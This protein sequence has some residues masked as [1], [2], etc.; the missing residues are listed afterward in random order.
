MNVKPPGLRRAALTTTAA[1]A[2]AVIIWASGLLGT[3][4]RAFLDLQTRWLQHEV[5]SDIIIVEIDA[6]SLNKLGRWPLP[7]S[8]YAKLLQ[9][10][11]QANARRIFMDIDFSTVST[12]AEDN[13]L[14]EVL[15]T[16][17]P[18][19]VLPAFWQP[20][21]NGA[22]SLLLNQPLAAFRAH[23]QL[24][25]VNL[26][27]SPDGL[28]RIIGGLSPLPNTHQP[29]WAVMQPDSH[30][31]RQVL[32]LDYR[33]SPHSFER[34]S[35]YDVLHGVSPSRFTGK[36]VFVGATALEL[37]DII[38]VP[39]HRVLPGILVQAI[40]YESARLPPLR[41][42][43]PA[44]LI[45]VLIPWCVFCVWLL[46]RQGWH[47]SPALTGA[48]IVAAL[49]ATALLYVFGNVL[50]PMSPFA[51]AALSALTGSLL[52][53]LRVE[54]WRSWRARRRSQERDALLRH[55]V[56]HSSDAIL[57]L[58]C[59]GV[60][61]TANRTA[62][63]ILGVSESALLGAPL[64]SIAPGLAR[65]LQ[66]HLAKTGLHE[67]W[68]D[69]ADGSRVAVEVDAAQLRWD[70][71]E[72]TTLTLRN[73]TAQRSR[74]A[75]LRHLALHDALT[76]LPN[77]MFLAQ[78]LATALREVMPD[79]SVALMML[80]LDGFKEVNDALGHSTGDTLLV[81]LGKRLRQLSGDTRHVCRLGGD[82]FAVLGTVKDTGRAE[83]LA[84]ELLLL[85]E[86]PILIR[87]IAVSLG[88]S[89]G[90]ALSPDHANDAETLLKR[91]DVALY[92]AK[93]KKSRVE[94][95]DPSSDIHSPRR[96]EI[97]T[98]LRAAV[99]KGELALHYQPKV[100]MRTGMAIEVEALC[101]WHSPVLGSVPPGE[102]I[103][104]AESTDLI[105]PLTEWT[106]RQALID[107]RAWHDEGLTLKVAVNLSARLLQ[108][109]HL[110]QW[111]DALLEET[112]VLPHWLELEI[113][114]SAIMTDPDRALKTLQALHERGILISI[115]DFGTG[116]SSL[117]YLRTLAV[118]RL[119][120]DRSFILSM[121]EG[122]KEQ[123]IV[124]STIKLA[125]GLGMQAVAEGIETQTHYE[126]LKTL[127]CDIGQ[128]H[129]IAKPMPPAQL[130]PWFR[131]QTPAGAANHPEQYSSKLSEC[132]RD[133]STL[134]RKRAG[135][136]TRD[137]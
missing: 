44:A 25:M 14:A 1:I 106:L 67:A 30:R 80:D 81:E 58:D 34:V 55:V 75:E 95:Y 57:T 9:Q 110:P 22:S 111:L 5:T 82:E 127:G 59:H 45:L 117:A 86:E 135:T 11:Q 118:D 72:I 40:A 90:I 4:D 129:F 126:I 114:E 2:V 130:I 41:L 64:A 50:V 24:G 76:G 92:V 49:L 48:L 23:A 19:P 112:G 74:E 12:P 113:T 69:T 47:K 70:R 66:N 31:E 88:A 26:I 27:P 97:L 77:R 63:S 136:S 109:A 39:L 85:I 15:A 18:P 61:R 93:R 73:V 71:Q 3:L 16:M 123:I 42:L 38:A 13:A 100:D 87:G 133:N 65:A 128:G 54:A 8:Y 122:P 7:R 62:S 32:Y 43:P 121:D 79:E 119:K 60:V 20:T 53:S 33:I 94:V 131:G 120:I 137:S 115:D 105:K 28:T 124:E 98:L 37:G 29:V 83:G 103:G 52:G 134:L 89:V 132:T 84:Q 96:V 10:L 102:F 51:V 56:D 107:C 36:T 116:Y 101:R 21:S 6:R 35:F 78:Q 91:A 68:F 104:L 46:W 108:D 17:T 125:H 99:N